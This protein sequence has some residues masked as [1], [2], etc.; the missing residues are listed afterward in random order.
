[1]NQI[2]QTIERTRSN[3]PAS[4]VWITVTFGLFLLAAVSCY[5][6]TVAEGE[7]KLALAPKETLLI[8]I[9]KEPGSVTTEDK[10]IRP[11]RITVPAGHLD[12][13]ELELMPV[14]TADTLAARAARD[15]TAAQ[16]AD[17]L[18]GRNR[19]PEAEG[20]E[21]S[22]PE[23]IAPPQPLDGDTTVA[24]APPTRLEPTRRT[25]TRAAKAKEPRAQKAKKSVRTNN[26]PD[27]KI[28][29]QKSTSASKSKKSAKQGV[30]TNT[31]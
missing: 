23:I 14:L 30:R 27:S 24:L 29:V 21:D 31:R 6:Q 12:A 16:Q 17:I 1:M 3:S 18:A 19:A 7:A 26:K 11:F 28:K 4:L 15:S 10:A 8:Q 9:K 2:E 5:A 13:A 22:G 20:A 25:A